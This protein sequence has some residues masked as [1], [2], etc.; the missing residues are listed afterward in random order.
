MIATCTVEGRDIGEAM[1]EIGQ[2]VTYLTPDSS[3][4]LANSL[5]V[6]F[7]FAD[8][9][10]YQLYEPRLGSDREAS[11]A[12]CSELGYVREHQCSQDCKP[13]GGRPIWA[14]GG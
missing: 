14:T 4:C 8:L 5:Q 7:R 9:L 10:E 6:P 1:L 13:G 2:A 12:W 11:R 3:P